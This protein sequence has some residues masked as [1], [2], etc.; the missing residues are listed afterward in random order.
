MCTTTLPKE[1]LVLS[2]SRR[3]E[4]L[5]HPNRFL[6]ALDKFPPEEVHSIV[7]WTKT[8]HLLFQEHELRNRLLE[9]DQIYMHITITGLGSSFLEPNTLHYQETLNLLPKLIDFVKSPAR[10]NIRF[11]PILNLVYKDGTFLS[12]FQFFPTIAEQCKDQ[13]ITKF[14]IS[15]ITA[16]EKVQRRLRVLGFVKFEADND[17]KEKQAK[18]LNV[19]GKELDVRIKGCCTQP[20][21]P[22]Y[23][24]INGK[25][26]TELHPK[27]EKCTL[28]KPEGQRPLCVCTKSRDIGWY[29]SCPNGCAYCY[30][31]PKFELE[32][33]LE[34]LKESK[35][36]LYWEK[37]RR[38]GN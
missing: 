13:G 35:K 19:W 36:G 34:M 16:Y 24:C 9:Y 37:E 2:A 22:A 10:I 25:L 4:L 7:L 18:Q 29:Y 32:K 17:L 12:N 1:K 21:F 11:D 3:V 23:G 30:G 33:S 27:K 5:C 28:E 6:N 20:F 14:T 31:Q 26:L 15:W 38:E 8:P